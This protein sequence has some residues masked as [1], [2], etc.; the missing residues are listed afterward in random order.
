M[1]QF[2]KEEREFF[3]RTKELVEKKVE[4]LKKSSEGR[5]H[6]N[7]LMAKNEA[8]IKKY[9][10]SFFDPFASLEMRY[11][12][13]AISQFYEKFFLSCRYVLRGSPEWMDLSAIFAD[14]ERFCFA[15]KN[16]VKPA[17]LDQYIHEVIR[18]R[19]QRGKDA[20]DNKYLQTAGRLLYKIYLNLSKVLDR[21]PQEQKENQVRLDMDVQD[22][23]GSTFGDLL[24]QA[25]QENKQIL[26]DFRI[27][28]LVSYL[29]PQGASS[30][31]IG[32]D[33]DY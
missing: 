20:V 25:V 18:N 30:P 9:P 32:H 15:A 10:D 4:A 27:T 28:E 1:T 24:N 17:M 5:F 11:F 8:K 29:A 3:E 21:L 22:W 16:P 12:I 7:Q 6:V 2:L 33:K 14:L 31:L 23:A 19:D 26:D 13:G